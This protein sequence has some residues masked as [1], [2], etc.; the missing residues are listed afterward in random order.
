VDAI[1]GQIPIAIVDLTSALPHVR[2]G[3]IK[4]LATLGAQRTVTAPDLP[5]MAEAGV[6]GFDAVGWFGI[7]APGGTPGDAIRKLNGETNRIMRLP[8][9]REK[10]LAAG[11]EPAT[12]TADEFGAL[13]AAEIPKWGHAVRASG[14]KAN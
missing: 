8:D 1:A 2:S 9:I 7:V 4:A 6:P 10:S 5:T 12:G 11:A 13:I 14:A 3:R